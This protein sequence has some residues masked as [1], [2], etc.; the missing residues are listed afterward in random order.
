MNNSDSPI[1]LQY[2]TIQE[3]VPD[4]IYQGLAKYVKDCNT[5]YSQPNFLRETITSKF[6]LPSSEWVFL[7]NGVDE[8]IR[9]CLELFGNSTH[10]FTPTEYST[11]HQFCPSVIAH[12]SLKNNL[13]SISSDKIEN[14]SLMIIAN[15]NNPVGYTEKETIIHLL[16]NNP[17]V[18][19]AIDEIYGEYS[20]HLS[21][22]DLL[23]KYNNLVVFCGMSKS[24]GLAGIRIGYILANPTILKKISEKATWSNVSYL[25][26]G[27]AQIALEHEEYYVGLRSSI[28]KRKKEIVDLLEK[29]E[30][31]VIPS[32]INT[33]TIK[34][35]TG[36]MAT[37]FVKLLLKKGILVNQG[38]SGGKVG[39]DSSYVSFVVGTENQMKMLTDS[40]I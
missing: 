36:S 6:K 22:V 20:P 2:T 13:Y 28:L 15:P 33:I 27:T 34:F 11:L 37:D 18:I 5:Y 21:V 39:I 10:I 16:S 4:F 19:I 24:Y 8:A 14:V 38:E 3:E 40:I 30:F 31:S 17:Q 7:T 23:Q 1:N 26:C 25:S 32:L 35:N 12:N 29:N 9:I